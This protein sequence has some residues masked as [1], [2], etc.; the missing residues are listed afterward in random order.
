[1]KV[2]TQR[3]FINEYHLLLVLSLML[4]KN[5]TYL[6]SYSTVYYSEISYGKKKT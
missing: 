3:N 5:Y 1:M 6:A 4:A 2:T